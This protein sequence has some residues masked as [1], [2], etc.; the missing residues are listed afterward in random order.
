VLTKQI[1]I[2]VL[3]LSCPAGVACAGPASAS[4]WNILY[5][6]NMPAHPSVVPNGWAFDFPK[7]E[8]FCKVKEKNCP[9]VHYVT[10]SY[11]RVIR[12]GATVVIK[13]RIEVTG[14]PIFNYHLEPSN[15]CDS[16]PNAHALLQRKNDDMVSPDNRYWS[17]PITIPLVPGD[18]SVSIPIR[19]GQWTNVDG[20][21]NKSGFN[22]TLKNIGN[23]GLTFGGGCFFGHGVSVRDGTA[24]F[25]VTSFAIE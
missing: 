1:T 13:G 14:T 17:N 10:T 18:F 6:Q 22:K 19:E 7:G 16:T 9:G 3:I 20:K 5:S 15:T 23:I 25:V 4:D 21:L 11:R 2:L 24:R 8:D 12:K